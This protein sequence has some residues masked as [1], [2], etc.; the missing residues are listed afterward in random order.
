MDVHPL[1]MVCIGIDPYPPI[2]TTINHPKPHLPPCQVG[3]LPSFL[4]R[5]QALLLHRVDAALLQRLLRSAHGPPGSAQTQQGLRGA[6]GDLLNMV[7][8]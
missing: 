5:F 3:P 6:D 1:K 2:K 8:V 7:C 4:P